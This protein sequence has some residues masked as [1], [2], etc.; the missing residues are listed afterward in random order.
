MRMSG[1]RK[2]KRYGGKCH[3]CRSRSWRTNQPMRAAYIRLKSH[4]ADRKIPFTISFRHFECFA[5]KS[6]LIGQQGLTGDALTV[7]RRDNLKG[8][9]VGNLQVMT[10]RKNSEK[11]AR[12]DAIR[13]KAGYAWNGGEAPDMELPDEPLPEDW[14]E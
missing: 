2:G 12:H 6:E 4:A 5:R 9:V 7:D 8:Y 11:K 10:R 14:Q 1:P 13:M 3:K